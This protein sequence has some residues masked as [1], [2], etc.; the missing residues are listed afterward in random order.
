MFIPWKID[1]VLPTFSVRVI[2]VINAPIIYPF[3]VRRG[4]IELI[5]SAMMYSRLVAPVPSVTW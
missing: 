4:Q 2:I 5:L 3:I 1:S